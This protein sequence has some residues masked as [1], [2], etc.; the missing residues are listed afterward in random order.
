MDALL[1]RHRTESDGLGEADRS[2]SLRPTGS[3]SA[4]LLNRALEHRLRSYVTSRCQ[5]LICYVAFSWTETVCFAIGLSSTTNS[6]TRSP[7]CGMGIFV[8]RNSVFSIEDGVELDDEVVFRCGAVRP[9]EFRV[10]R[11]VLTGSPPGEIT[12]S[13]T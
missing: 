5:M 10:R 7:A 1:R 8:T 6:K 9:A 12:F 11:N 13:L 3:G 2:K 4:S